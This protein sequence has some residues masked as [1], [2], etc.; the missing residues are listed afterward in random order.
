MIVEN[1][2]IERCEF[3]NHDAGGP[4]VGDDMVLSQQQHML[5]I[6]QLQQ[7]TTDEWSLSK[8]ERCTSLIFGEFGNAIC[9]GRFA[10]GTQI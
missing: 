8:I 10:Q 6:S 2:V 4:T 9:A 3:A 5:L 1:S 7:L